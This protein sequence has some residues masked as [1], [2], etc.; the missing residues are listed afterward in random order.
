MQPAQELAPQRKAGC[1][2]RGLGCTKAWWQEKQSGFIEQMRRDSVSR[3]HGL[4]RK[5]KLVWGLED[6]KSWLWKIAESWSF[7]SSVIAK[8]SILYLEIPWP[9]SY[10]LGDMETVYLEFACKRAYITCLMGNHSFRGRRLLK[11]K[12]KAGG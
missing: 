12:M 1:A 3:E 10:L 2:S 4:E 5:S 11:P 9:Q 8:C 7:G 6:Y